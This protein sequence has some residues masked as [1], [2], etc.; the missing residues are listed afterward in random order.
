MLADYVNCC[1]S[2]SASILC[3]R[4][5]SGREKIESKLVKFTKFFQK[6]TRVESCHCV[7]C[8]NFMS[9]RPNYTVIA[10]KVSQNCSITDVFLLNL[11]HEPLEEDSQFFLITFEFFELLRFI[12]ILLLTFMLF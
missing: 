7:M 10:L 6:L 4:T 11:K 2:L 8:H 3:C 12:G 9:L 5:K 1:T